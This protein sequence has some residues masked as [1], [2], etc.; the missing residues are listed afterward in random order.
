MEASDQEGGPRCA[1]TGEGPGEAT[2]GH[3]CGDRLPKGCWGWRWEA[4]GPG[5]GRWVDPVGS[6]APSWNIRVGAGR[7]AG[8]VEVQMPPCGPLLPSQEGP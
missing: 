8:G 1:A 6:E 2:G 5:L 4:L 7:R 3:L